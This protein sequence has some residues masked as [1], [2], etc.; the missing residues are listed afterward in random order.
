LKNSVAFR[1]LLGAFALSFF[2]TAVSPFLPAYENQES[3]DSMSEQGVFEKNYSEKTDTELIAIERDLKRKLG[4]EPAN[5]DYYYDLSNVYAVLFDRTRKKKGGQA[6]DW[7]WRSGD[8]LEKTVMID[9]KKKVALYNL[10]VVY[11]R[12]GRMERARE[13]LK[14]AIRLCD[15]NKEDPYIAFASWMQIGAIYEEQGFFEE[16][17]EAYQKAREYDYGNQDVREALYQL[18]M[19]KKGDGGGK[20]DYTMSP[21]GG[22]GLPI[23]NSG[24]SQRAMESGTQDQQQGIAQALPALG[25]MLMQKFGG[26]GGGEDSSGPSQ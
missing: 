11:K 8:A 9:P 15:A 3:E 18:E 12:Q 17:K 1:T 14:K 23:G 5:A 16:A 4:K 26:G 10:G 19:K 25:Q 21:M 6:D 24:S 2:L 7:L 13:E 22:M 20:S